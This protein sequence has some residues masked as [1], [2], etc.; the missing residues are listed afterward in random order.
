MNEKEARD[1]PFYKKHM[2]EHWF[3][4]LDLTHTNTNTKSFGGLTLDY[5]HLGFFWN[6]N[7][8]IGHR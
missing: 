4:L 1:G 8:G 7:W 6:P 3:D 2:A 5:F